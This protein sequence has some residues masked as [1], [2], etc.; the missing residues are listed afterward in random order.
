[1]LWRGRSHHDK[2]SPSAKGWKGTGC[3][4]DV[5]NDPCATS[6]VL[7]RVNL[8]H[9]TG[10]TIKSCVEW[11]IFPLFSRRSVMQQVERDVSINDN[12]I[13]RLCRYRWNE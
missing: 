3:P 5:D 13:K 4:E 12:Y 6:C 9:A 2:L 7:S 11:A 8:S 10:R 1:M